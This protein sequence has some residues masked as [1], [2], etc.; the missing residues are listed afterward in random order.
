MKSKLEILFGEVADWERKHPGEEA[1]GHLGVSGKEA[2]QA[3]S[4]SLVF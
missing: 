3:K 4:H 1:F 2:S